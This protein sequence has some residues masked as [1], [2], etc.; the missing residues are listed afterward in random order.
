MPRYAENLQLRTEGWDLLK[1]G[2]YS[3][4]IVLSLNKASGGKLEKKLTEMKDELMARFGN[5]TPARGQLVESVKEQLLSSPGSGAAAV[6]GAPGSGAA[7][8][9]GAA[10]ALSPLT[11]A[12]ACA[13]LG[14][15]VWMLREVRAARQSV[16]GPNLHPDLQARHFTHI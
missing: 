10:S 2:K 4:R 14:V 8:V 3:E 13:N 11:L 7:A 6:S 9:S 16:R 1:M 5:E 15:S 12:V